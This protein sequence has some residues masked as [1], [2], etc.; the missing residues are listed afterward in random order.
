RDLV[1][2]RFLRGRASNSLAIIAEG[3]GQW[4]VA[5][6]AGRDPALQPG[7]AV[8]SELAAAARPLHRRH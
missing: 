6:A 3:R 7:R 5:V 2:P 1:N 4:E 8:A